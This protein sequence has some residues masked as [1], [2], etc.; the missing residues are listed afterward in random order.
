VS[1]PR[2]VAAPTGRN[3]EPILEVLRR[4]LPAR[5]RVLELASGSGEHAVHFA[6]ALPGLVFQPS[7]PDGARRASIAAYASD[8]SLPNLLPPIDLDATATWPDVAADAVLCINMIHIA[9]WAAAEGLVRGAAKL[10]AMLILYG[11]Y[12]RHGRHTAPSNEAFDADLRS[13]NAAWGVRDMEAVAGLAAANGYASPE[14]VPM[15]A[16]NVMLI[17]RRPAIADPDIREMRDEDQEQVIALWHEAGVARPWNDPATD[18]AFARRGPQSTILVMEQDAG[19]VASAMLGQD[20]HRGWVY[21][22]AIAPQ[23][24]GRGLGRRMMAAAESWLAA[25]GVWKVQLLVRST[26]EQ[27]RNFYERLG[28]KDTGSACLQKVMLQARQP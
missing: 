24:Q 2:I 28:Y 16:N 7:D 4:V 3:R 6:R 8:A 26:N 12:R 9:P 17:F 5:G 10:G 15:P 11:P 20:G 21:Y 22:V 23:M 13:R 19:I 18:I 1:D 14:V 27:A 25:Q